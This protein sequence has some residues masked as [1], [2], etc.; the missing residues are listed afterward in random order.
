[1]KDKT[2]FAKKNLLLTGVLILVFSTAIKESLPLSDL[3]TV[4]DEFP[5]IGILLGIFEFSFPCGVL[6]ILGGFWLRLRDKYPLKARLYISLSGI[7]IGGALISSG[8]WYEVLDTLIFNASGDYRIP[9]VSVILSRLSWFLILG[10]I[11][12]IPIIVAGVI[13]LIYYGGKN[14]PFL[15]R[16]RLRIPFYDGLLVLLLGC[17]SALCGPLS[18][19]LVTYFSGW[20][21]FSF[22]IGM[23]MFLFGGGFSLICFFLL[24]HVF[25]STHKQQPIYTAIAAILVFIAHYVVISQYMSPGAL[26]WTDG[27]VA[28]IESR[29]NLDEL[30]TWALN[31]ISDYQAGTLAIVG[32]A[33]YWTPAKDK[34]DP[35][36]LPHYIQDIWAI[37]PSV[38]IVTPDRGTV[39]DYCVVISWSL[40]GILVG[41]PDFQSQWTPW[42]IRKLQPGIWVYHVER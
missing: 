33:D 10:W 30:Q 17:V 7:L 1:M 24:R 5:L 2:F 36:I 39:G 16:L 18:Y 20:G 13:G 29:V 26:I 27:F 8:V 38:S 14:W 6:L 28:G 11:Y 4:A 19:Y 21:L 32:E 40:H 42:H 25:Q 3:S 37:P 15:S 35:D 34:L 9:G 12:G 23:L 31:A 22:G 41:T